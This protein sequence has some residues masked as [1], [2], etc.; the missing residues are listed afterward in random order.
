MVTPNG[1][2]SYTHTS[3]DGTTQNLLYWLDVTTL[4]TD[5]IVK[6]K[7][8]EGTLVSTL[9][10][11]AAVCPLDPRMAS[12]QTVDATSCTGYMGSISGLATD[13]SKGAM[14]Y[15]LLDGSATGGTVIVGTGGDY[16]VLFDDCAGGTPVTFMYES[17]CTEDGSIVS[18][19]VTVNPPGGMVTADAVDDTAA[20]PKNFP[21][22]GSL[23]AND[24]LCSAGTTSY[25]VN[26]PSANG[27]TIV[28]SSGSFVFVPSLGY[29]GVTTFT[30]DILCDGV[31]KDTATVTITILDANAFDDYYIA[32]FETTTLTKDNS[33]ND[34]LCT[35]GI[36]TYQWTNPA[37]PGAQGTITGTPTSFTYTPSNG[38]VGTGYTQYDILCSGIVIDTATVYLLVAK[39]QAAPDNFQ[40]QKDTPITETVTDA[41]IPC[42]NGATT[43]YHLLSNPGG[44]GVLTE[45]TK[46]CAT[47]AAI[48]DVRVT[49]WDQSTG[50]FT[51]TPMNGFTGDACFEYFVRCTNP[52]GQ[53]WDSDPATIKVTVL[54]GPTSNIT[55]TC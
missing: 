10:L 43:T 51:V 6:L 29:T 47:A 25:Q 41:A 27:A 40:T 36:T 38:F 33:T 20:G 52:D 26:T 11:C 32:L 54:A 15:R 16:Y 9:D 49:G 5:G 8:S 12:P 53:T 1:D 19:L 34:T 2:G 21:V 37:H 42:N 18:A 17:V 31:V 13:C 50:V 24:T 30:Y 35:A 44:A 7:N 22:A 39:G 3:G 46:N 23:P 48:T 28:G 14:Y 55:I 45:Q 4:G